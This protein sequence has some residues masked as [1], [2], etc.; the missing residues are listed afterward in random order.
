[1]EYEPEVIL[2]E[3]S[4]APPAPPPPPWPSPPLPPPATR[5]YSAVALNPVGTVSVPEDVKV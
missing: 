3:E 4:K 2:V 5:R 1:M